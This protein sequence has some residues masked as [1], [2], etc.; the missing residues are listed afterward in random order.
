VFMLSRVFVY[1]IFYPT[2]YDVWFF[3]LFL[4]EG[5]GFFESFKYPFAVDK[6]K[7]S[8]I[9]WIFSRGLLV[10]LFFSIYYF[11]QYPRKIWTVIDY[12]LYLYKSGLDWGNDKVTNYHVN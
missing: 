3:P 7:E 2:G 11:Y 12:I 9:E 10:L 1:L 4:W 6:R 8:W 5:C